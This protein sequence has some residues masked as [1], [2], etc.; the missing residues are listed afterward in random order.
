MKTTKGVRRETVEK[1]W[2]HV[3]CVV[4]DSW[5]F[6][7]F[8]GTY[9]F[10]CVLLDI[11]LQLFFFLGVLMADFFLFITFTFFFSYFHVL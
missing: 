3:W 7:G 1:E 8:L 9:I 10:I 2:D 4:I 6:S 5:Y 11:Y